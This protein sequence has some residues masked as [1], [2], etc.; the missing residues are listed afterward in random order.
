[1][2]R[3]LTGLRVLNTRPKGQAQELSEQIRQAGGIAI[4]CPTL[5]I[6]PLNKD[7]LKALP[8]LNEVNQALF[9]SANAVH[10]CCTQLKAHNIPWPRH[11]KVIAIGAASA[12]ALGAFGIV[13]HEVPE[14]SNSEHVLHLH[15]LQDLQNQTI[16]LFKGQGGRMLIE[17]QLSLRGAKLS[18]LEV[19]KRV[20]PTLSHPFTTSLWQDDLVDIILLTSEQSII[21][22]FKLFSKEAH[23]WLRSKPSLVLSE[24]LVKAASSAGMNQILLSQPESV[25]DRLFD[26]YQGLLHGQ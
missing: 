25:M 22:L 6:K 14:Q 18:I 7:W 17:E 4:E 1:M 20:L 12:K 23:S 13:V 10:F 24:R 5:E 2:K 21:N 3:V 16:L 26:Y 8:P 11:I 9:V 19:Y 15:T